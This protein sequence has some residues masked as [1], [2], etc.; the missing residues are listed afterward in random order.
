MNKGIL[1]KKIIVDSLLR[2][3]QWELEAIKGDS[4]RANRILAKESQATNRAE[5]DLNNSLH[6]FRNLV[7]G[8]LDLE[9]AA[10]E[11]VKSF[12]SVQRQEYRECENRKMHIQIEVEKIA[13]QL[14]RKLSHTTALENVSESTGKQILVEEEKE[15]LL[16]NEELWLQRLGVRK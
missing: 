12:I 10:V 9:L 1:R 5:E 3:E 7:N 16:S 2:R 14:K 15:A 6:E 8:N 4:A 11:R 13:E